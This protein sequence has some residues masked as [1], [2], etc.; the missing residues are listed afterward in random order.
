MAQILSLDMKD[1]QGKP[2]HWFCDLQ[3]PSLRLDELSS[4]ALAIILSNLDLRSILTLRLAS[5]H[6]S[7]LSHLRQLNIGY[8]ADTP[9][10]D[11]SL[12]LFLHRH[13]SSPDSPAIILRVERI[14]L[15]HW[16][17]LS[18][19]CACTN[20][21]VLKLL[22][23]SL[24]VLE[25]KALVRLLP[26]C[27]EGL[28]L[29]THAKILDDTGLPRLKCLTHLRLK[30]SSDLVDDVD[31]VTY[32]GKGIACLPKLRQLILVPD[33]ESMQTNI[34]DAAQVRSASLQQLAISSTPFNGIPDI[35]AS[36]PNLHD[37]WLMDGQAF[38]AWLNA[39]PIEHLK[40]Y[41]SFFTEPVCTSKLLCRSLDV[42]CRPE[43]FSH[44]WVKS[45]LDMP[46]L[47][48]LKI[49]VGWHHTAQLLS[50]I[51]LQPYL[52]LLQK[53]T[54]HV[55]GAVDLEVVAAGIASMDHGAT[56]LRQNGHCL[57]CLC[58]SCKDQLLA[59]CNEQHPANGFMDLNELV[60]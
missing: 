43:H 20:L 52:T 59:R 34:L 53:A 60:P 50:Q 19:A 29:H 57:M 25:A 7:S 30:W 37:I 35:G 54:V 28:C 22:R 12:A 8:S 16:Y 38:P 13:C 10:A 24:S 42:Y 5:K 51:S 40:V 18:M 32:Y 23:Q 46:L 21:R 15:Q 49:E 36:F 55:R 1:H 2:P 11:G 14:Q 4:E 33:E 47:K 31:P 44:I 27:L 41:S 9:A 48:H 6:F 45:L 17:I 39:Q 56:R 58:T 3:S 26:D